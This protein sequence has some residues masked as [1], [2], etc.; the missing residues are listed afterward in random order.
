M[1]TVANFR[2]NCAPGLKL[3]VDDYVHKATAWTFHETIIRGN[4][5]VQMQTE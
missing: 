1:A 5:P 4:G 2:D 3:A